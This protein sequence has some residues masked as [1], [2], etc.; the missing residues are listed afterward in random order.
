MKKLTCLISALVLLAACTSQ[1]VNVG[2][3]SGFLGNKYSQL[4]PATS[5]TGAP[6]LRWISPKLNRSNYDNILVVTPV[7]YPASQGNK[8]VSNKTLHDILSY[9]DNSIKSQVA[10]D[11]NIV[12]T[13]GPRTLKIRSAIT[14]VKTA[15]EGFQP[16]EVIPVALVAAAVTSS[17]GSRDQ[18]VSLYV[19]FE[20]TDS[21]SGEILAL[22]VRKGFG[23]P[24][25]NTSESVKLDNLKPVIDQW[26]KDAK[27][28]FSRSYKEQ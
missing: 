3:Y 23:S 1:S 28:F 20:I 10:P 16:Y 27:L 8:Q 12:P 4:K 21:V 24:L 2:E 17:T 26:G 15:N 25:E 13:A 11:L 7:L 6:V 18:E 22:G 19:E 5:P 9:M 14:G